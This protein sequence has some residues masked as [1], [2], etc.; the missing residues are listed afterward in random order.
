MRS[1][2][3]VHQEEKNN[4]TEMLTAKLKKNKHFGYLNKTINKQSYTTQIHYS[5]PEQLYSKATD[6]KAVM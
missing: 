5:E 6:S 4:K 1:K 3:P 2:S